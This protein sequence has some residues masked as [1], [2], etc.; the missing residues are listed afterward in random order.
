MNSFG[1]YFTVSIYGESHTDSV[2][3]LID[4]VPSGIQLD[5]S[6]FKND[7]S[8]RQGGQVNTTKRIESDIP[9]ISSGIFEGKTTGTPILINFKNENIN[10]KDYLNLVSHPRPSHADLTFKN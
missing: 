1:K 9:C 7:L 3:I 6:D 2:G 4:N 10:S 5:V 8:K